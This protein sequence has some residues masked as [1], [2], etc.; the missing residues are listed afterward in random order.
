MVMPSSAARVAT[1]S[2]RSLVHDLHVH[3]EGDGAL[4]HAEPDRAQADDAHRRAEQAGGLAV[5]LLLPPARRAGRRR[6]R[7]CAGRWRA[8]APW[9]APR[10]RRS[11]GRA[12]WRR[13]R[14]GPRPP[15]CRS[16]WSRPRPGSPARAGRRP[17]RRRSRTLVLRTTSTSKPAMRSGRSSLPSS[18]STT[19]SWPRCSSS[20]SAGCGNESAIRMRNPASE[21]TASTAMTHPPRHEPPATRTACGH[22]NGCAVG[23][24]WGDG[25]QP[26]RRARRLLPVGGPG[27]PV[28]TW[29]RLERLLVP[30]LAARAGVPPPRAQPQPR[31]P[32][33][34]G[35]VG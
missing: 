34:A 9:S 1:C 10:P 23:A 29:R 19:H 16:C 26:P 3:A 14:H 12:R 2:L 20:S 27:R 6:C 22:A 33:R 25:R 35:R 8:A 13:A 5:G 7:G 30:V 15:R 11:C 28:R 31:R 32:P 24:P 4:G 18:A 17:R 21:R